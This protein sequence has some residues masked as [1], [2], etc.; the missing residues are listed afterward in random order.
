MRI[1]CHG[2]LHNG[3]CPCPAVFCSVS[4]K[5]CFGM[6]FPFFFTPFFTFPW[7]PII[8]LQSYISCST[9]VVSLYIF[10]SIRSVIL[11]LFTAVIYTHLHSLPF[12]LCHCVN[13]YTHC[14]RE[15]I[16]ILSFKRSAYFYAIKLQKINPCF[17]AFFC[18]VLLNISVFCYCHVYQ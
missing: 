16:C 4:I 13:I 8:A 3:T 15:Q 18:F 7:P 1:S 9:L 10:L 5:C 17:V 14:L 6:V 2:P 11:E 12:H